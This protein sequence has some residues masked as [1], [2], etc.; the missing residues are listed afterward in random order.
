MKENGFTWKK[1]KKK[2]PETDDTLQKLKQMLIMLTIW[3]SRNCTCS[4]RIPAASLVQAARNIGLYVNSDEAISTFIGK[5][6][7]LVDQFFSNN[8]SSTE[9]D[10]NICIGMAW[11]V[12]DSLSTKWKS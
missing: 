10:V 8:I 2:R 4:N 7:K 1:K 5:L 9:S 12:I 3:H 11:I 6:L